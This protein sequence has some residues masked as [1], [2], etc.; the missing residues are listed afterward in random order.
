MSENSEKAAEQAE[1]RTVEQ[2]EEK[3]AERKES[4]ETGKEDRKYSERNPLLL[5]MGPSGNQLWA[6][7]ICI[8]LHGKR[9]GCN[10]FR[11]QSIACSNRQY[12]AY[13]LHR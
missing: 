7:H 8:Y 10:G 11:L 12:G 5:G 6:G 2:I 13:H 9:K 1:D 3:T 4:C